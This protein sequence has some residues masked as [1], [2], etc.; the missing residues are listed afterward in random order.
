MRD[1][2]VPWADAAAACLDCAEPGLF[3]E[4]EEGVGSVEGAARW[5]F[6]LRRGLCVLAGVLRRHEEGG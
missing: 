5:M 3:D 4:E 6:I 2:A 1:A